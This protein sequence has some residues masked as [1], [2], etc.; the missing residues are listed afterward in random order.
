M[1]LFDTKPGEVRIGDFLW[2]PV[3]KVVYEPGADLEYQTRNTIEGL[4]VR[5]YLFEDHGGELY[6]IHATSIYDPKT[7]Q[8]RT[9]WHLSR[10]YWT[11][12]SLAHVTQ[13]T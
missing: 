8:T 11:E 5:D 1:P 4:D 2:N 7:Q 10:K 12:I 6:R 13:L 9:I 3:T